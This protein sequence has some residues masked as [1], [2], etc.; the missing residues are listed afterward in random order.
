MQTWL[1]ALFG[2]GGELS[3]LQ[4][5]S[6]AIG[7]FFLILVLIRISG[8]R[9][10]GQHT[11]FDACVTV[12]LGAVL[13]RAVVGASPFLAT[14]IASLSIVLLHRLVAVLAVRYPAIDR[15]IKGEPRTLAYKG[16][17]DPVQMRWALVSDADLVEAL[18]ENAN[19]ESLDHVER[20]TLERNG[21]ISILRADR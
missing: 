8:R 10:F 4:M 6:R 19:T 12:L 5:S 7:C 16:L 20:A 13:S 11:P 21:N 3:P 18:R 17:K 1:L 2:D 15:L 9:S 14:A